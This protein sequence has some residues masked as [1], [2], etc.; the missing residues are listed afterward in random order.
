MCLRCLFFIELH[1]EVSD[2]AISLSTD[3]PHVEGSNG[4]TTVA[5]LFTLGAQCLHR[6]VLCI[7][8]IFVYVM[9][10]SCIYIYHRFI[11]RFP[12][13]IAFLPPCGWMGGCLVE[14]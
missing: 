10:F 7:M 6:Y 8:P 14:V 1:F 4:A 13:F 11:V 12:I 5:F 3:E 9:F 2:E